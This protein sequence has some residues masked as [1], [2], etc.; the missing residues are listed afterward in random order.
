ML[1]TNTPQNTLGYDS[2]QFDKLCDQ[3][4]VEQSQAKRFQLYHQAERIAV[5]DAPW[6]PIYFQKDVE[7][8]N[9]KLSGVE[10]MLMGHLPHKHT[11]L[12][13]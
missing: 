5:D 13:P 10:D 6:V 2:P 1:H 7:L 4:D 11:T 8:W 12:A 3:A 9:P